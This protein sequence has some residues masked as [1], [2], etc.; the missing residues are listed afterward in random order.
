MAKIAK[1]SA[2]ICS[3]ALI[4]VMVMLIESSGLKFN[5]TCPTALCLGNFW[6]WK[7][8]LDGTFRRNVQTKVE[9]LVSNLAEASAWHEGVNLRQGSLP[10]LALACTN[11]FISKRGDVVSS[12]ASDDLSARTQPILHTH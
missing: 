4:A 3:R 8:K 2:R 11:I 6:L 9:W 7:E 5:Q 1:E 10:A 12:H